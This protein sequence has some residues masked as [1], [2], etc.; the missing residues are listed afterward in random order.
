MDPN[1]ADLSGS[2]DVASTTEISELRRSYS[3]AA[4]I[5]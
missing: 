5:T 2:V 3:E 4:K 1:F